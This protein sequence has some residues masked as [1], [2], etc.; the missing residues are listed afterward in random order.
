[1]S[2]PERVDVAVIG[3]G[4][5]GIGI[6]VAL[7]KLDLEFAI[8]EREA[9]GESFRNW[10]EE[11]RF[12]TPS[13]PSNSF[14]IVDLNAVSPY[15]SPGYTLECQQPSGEEYADYL[16]AV[17]E[18]HE[19]PVFTGVTVTDVS[20]LEADSVD[21]QA[22]RAV[23]GGHGFVLETSEGTV[24]SD[25]LIWAG[26]QFGNPR[27]DVFPGSDLCVHSS[28]VDSWADHAAG[29]STDDFF[30]I[31]GYESGID[32]AVGLVEAGASVR[33]IDRGAP[34]LDRDPDP[35]NVLAPYTMERLEAA[36]DTDRLEV[37]GGMTVDA[38]SR[39]D[40][41]S[42]E[43]RASAVRG[44]GER[45]YTTPTRPILATGFEPNL[46]PVEE[47]FP[48]EEGVIEL[49]DRD[50]SPSVPG[51]F[52]AGPDVTHNGIKFCFI[53]KFRARFPVVAE[54]IGDRLG[55][56]TDPLEEYREQNMYLEDVSCCEPEM[57]DC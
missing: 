43:I 46:G 12:I 28:A 29:A 42:F 41:G 39:T 30:V 51:L 34:W 26:G 14:G 54:T 1:M 53:Y 18:L 22:T 16:E 24:E 37:A 38:V 6:G 52:L 9:I 2:P 23:D 25:F 7:S 56:D 11:M 3:A 40:D 49:T 33:V 17:A 4:A 19:L 45:T 21:G 50:E 31:G 10:P 44:P 8:L 5:A 55:V 47:L 35:S 32:A 48:R 27:R 20:P 57:C 15:T 36:A 13:F